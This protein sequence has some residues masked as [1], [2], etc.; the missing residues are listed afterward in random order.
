MIAVLDEA[1]V[2]FIPSRI[3]ATSETPEASRSRCG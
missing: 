3:V 1:N 2:P